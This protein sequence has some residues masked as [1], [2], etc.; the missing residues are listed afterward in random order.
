MGLIIAVITTLV[1]IAAIVLWFN[2][3]TQYPPYQAPQEPKQDID[4]H[5]PFPKSRP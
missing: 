4:P 2:R 3:E 5:W 1:V